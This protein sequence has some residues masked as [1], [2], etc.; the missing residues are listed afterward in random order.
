MHLQLHL[1]Q[2]DLHS[3]FTAKAAGFCHAFYSAP[4]DLCT[5]VRSIGQ[6]W[7]LW[8]NAS[9]CASSRG[10]RAFRMENWSKRESCFNY[11]FHVRKIMASYNRRAVCAKCPVSASLPTTLS[12]LH[13][14][15]PANRYIL[16]FPLRLTLRVATR[17]GDTQRHCS[18][19]RTRAPSSTILSG[20]ALSSKNRSIIERNTNSTLLDETLWDEVFCFT[21]FIFYGC[22]LNDERTPKL[23]NHVRLLTKVTAFF[24]TEMAEMMVAKQMADDH[25]TF[26]IACQ[27][28][29]RLSF[30]NMCWSNSSSRIIAGLVAEKSQVLT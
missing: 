21:S 22:A 17:P 11:A 18:R 27:G 6:A 10:P 4:M 2:I 28:G 19:T 1:Q 5:I 3:H 24:R 25:C 16:S 14:W 23:W 9:T 12:L 26:G 30:L 7:A 20:D 29:I 8:M 13:A 15:N